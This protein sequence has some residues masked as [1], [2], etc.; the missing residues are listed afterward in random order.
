VVASIYNESPPTIMKA[1]L[2]AGVHFGHQKKRWNPKMRSYIFTERNGIHIIDLN[3]TLPLLEEA[4]RFV[5]EL[6]AGGGRILFV[7]TKKQAQEVV[8][9]EATRCGQFYVNRRWLGGTLTNFVTIRSRLRT[10]KQ[11]QS[12]RDS[13]ELDYLPNQ[14]AAAARQEL[15]R[16]ERTLGGMR[17]MT[18]LPGAVFIIDPK[19][20]HLAVQEAPRLKIPVIA[21]T[22][23][24]CDPDD[25]DYIIPGNDDAIR[26]VRL[27]TA[28]I[29]DAAIQG[30]MRSQSGRDDY[31]A[32][33][34]MDTSGYGDAG[35]PDDATAVAEAA[36][37]NTA[38]ADAAAV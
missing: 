34:G 2:Q 38:E 24:N 7:G 17:D 13:G 25:V 21:L 29:A 5:E 9:R 16:L 31:G 36:E 1:M 15:E 14:E 35:L 3:Q 26:S 27:L 32:D 20:E 30:A 18:G 19:R 28:A 10:L 6:V 23:T 37:V 11:L 33:F 8:A 22:D 4:F 12:Q